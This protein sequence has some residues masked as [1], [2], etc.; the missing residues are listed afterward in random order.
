MRNTIPMSPIVPANGIATTD[1]APSQISAFLDDVE[2]SRIELHGFVILQHGNTVADGWWHP[3]R[4]DVRHQ[5]YSLSKSFTSTAAGFAVSEG[6]LSL[7][8]TVISFFPNKVPKDANDFL[9]SMKIRHLLSMA[10][11]HEAEPEIRTSKDWVKEFLAT[12]P[13][14]EP[15]THFLYNSIATYMVSA[16]LQ[17][18]TG[19]TVRDY[20]MPRLFTPLGIPEPEWDSCPKGINAGGWGLWLTTGEIARFGQFLLNKGIWN[21]VRLLPQEWVDTASRTHIDNS[22]QSNPDWKVGYGFQFWRCRHGFYRGDGAF[23]QYC[24]V[25]DEHDAIIAITSGVADMQAVLD[26]VWKH[27]IPEQHVD[28]EKK[29]MEPDKADNLAERCQSLQYGPPVLSLS[30]EESTMLFDKWRGSCWNISENPFMIKAIVF[31]SVG[32][33]TYFEI[34]DERGS[35]RIPFG[36]GHW[37]ES[38]STFKRHNHRKRRKFISF[39]SANW[40]TP[41]CFQ[42]TCRFPETP[43]WYTVDITQKSESDLEIKLTTNVSF[44]PVNALEAMGKLVMA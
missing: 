41:N 22:S 25:M 39:A 24:I 42:L 3:Y 15:G 26:L 14:R 29:I 40:K 33:Q 13:T 19:L 16:I 23:G 20:L 8:D 27:L 7:D 10:T 36:W 5:L 12:P 11:G 34:E 17:K 38:N 37:V 18:I 31:N 44:G 21:G 32:R 9:R 43:D 28:C 30:L 2:A 6:I 1:I 35:H 4:S